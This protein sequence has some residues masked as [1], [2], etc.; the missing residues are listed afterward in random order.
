VRFIGKGDVAEQAMKERAKLGRKARQKQIRCL[1]LAAP[2]DQSAHF[3]VERGDVT[4]LLG[5]CHESPHVR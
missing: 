3:G 5:I 2:E 1:S 4:A